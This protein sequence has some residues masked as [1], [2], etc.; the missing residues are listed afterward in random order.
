MTFKNNKY[1]I[2]ISKTCEMDGYLKNQSIWDNEIK[3]N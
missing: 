1:K 2:I 3:M